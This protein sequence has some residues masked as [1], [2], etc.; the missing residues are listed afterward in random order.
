MTEYGKWEQE[1]VGAACLLVWAQGE[2]EGGGGGVMG[3]EGAPASASWV[4]RGTGGEER[5]GGGGMSGKR[6]K[7]G[8]CEGGWKR[9]NQLQ[10]LA[11][12][13]TD[14]IHLPP[15]GA[16]LCVNR[17]AQAA[18]QRR[19]AQRQARGRPLSVAMLQLEMPQRRRQRR[20]EFQRRRQLPRK[21]RR[22]SF[23]SRKTEKRISQ[24]VRPFRAQVSTC[25]A[26]R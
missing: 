16:V 11:F 18:M 22:K 9:H 26:Q 23:R 2:G 7:G 5:E 1:Q 10:V 17:K 21:G 12:R 13:L 6:G 4:L 3:R 20:R 25:N 19:P 8:G 14:L 24:A 15:V